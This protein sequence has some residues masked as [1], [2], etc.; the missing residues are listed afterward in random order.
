MIK[1]TPSNKVSGFFVPQKPE[2]NYADSSPDTNSIS[3]LQS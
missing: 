2:N 3:P 1:D